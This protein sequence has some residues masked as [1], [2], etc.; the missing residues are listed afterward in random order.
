MEQNELV[1]NI[2]T[3][4]LVPRPTPP[5]RLW[6]RSSTFRNV[7][8]VMS[9]RLLDEAQRHLGGQNVRV[10]GQSYRSE[11]QVRVRGQS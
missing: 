6:A 2:L 3:T 9:A 7:M 4:A 8:P 5:D 1:H 11:L 10:T